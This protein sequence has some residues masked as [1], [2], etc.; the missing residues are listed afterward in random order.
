MNLKDFK[1]RL[2]CKKS[3]CISEFQQ[4]FVPVNSL[5]GIVPCHEEVYIFFHWL[6]LNKWRSNNK[7]W[8]L[9]TLDVFH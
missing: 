5:E 9:N 1:I 3:L 8:W 6:V 7:V 4:S 2:M